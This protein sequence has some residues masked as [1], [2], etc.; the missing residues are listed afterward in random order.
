MKY[1]DPRSLEM[2]VK[3]AAKSS[4]T[5]T[6][7]AIEGFYFDRF[8]CRVFSESEPAFILKGGQS[9]LART[10]DAR[11]TRDIDLISRSLD[12]DEAVEE[13]KRIAAIDLDDYVSFLFDAAEPIKEQDEYRS[14]YKVWFQT[15]LG[16]SEKTRISIDLIYDEVFCDDPVRVSP[17]SRLTVGD[18]A[19]TDYLLYPINNTIADK[20]CAVVELH[21]GKPSSR[22]K[23]LV[24]LAVIF[25]TQTISATDLRKKIELEVRLRKLPEIKAFTI[26]ETWT[27]SYQSVFSKLAKETGLPIQLQSME[28]AFEFVAQC[29]NPVI[30]GDKDGWQWSPELLTWR[31][32][33]TGKE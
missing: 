19:T 3:A 5:D 7:K 18:L 13:L 29:L 23:D 17:V 14:G 27:D 1:K 21:D 31:T 9:M 24:D 20:V 12:I 33:R 6:N 4:D 10:M 32:E 28:A 30:A 8:L 16:V 22:T 26:P 25:S 11:T 2:A 15:Y